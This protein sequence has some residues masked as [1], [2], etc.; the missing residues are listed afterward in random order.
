M[1]VND[2]LDSMPRSRI[3]RCGREQPVYRTLGLAGFH[4][5]LIVVLGAGLLTGR[6]LLVIAGL[7]LVCACFFYGYAYLRRLITGQEQHVLLEHVWL[8]LGG[9]AAMLWVLHEPILSYLDI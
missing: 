6:S 1:S 4:A 8:A 3:F 2:F 7:G 9:S 5:A